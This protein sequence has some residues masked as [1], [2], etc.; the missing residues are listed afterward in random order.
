[1]LPLG[2]ENYP[3]QCISYEYS[4]AYNWAK[5]KSKQQKVPWKVKYKRKIYG[6]T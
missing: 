6:I 4:I 3:A 1:M 5:E 2:C